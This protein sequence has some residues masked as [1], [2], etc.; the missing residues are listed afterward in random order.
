MWNKKSGCKFIK[1]VGCKMNKEIADILVEQLGIKNF[2]LQRQVEHLK[3][4][5]QQAIALI[6]D[7]RFVEALQLL[8]GK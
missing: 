4:Q 3:E 8:E 6:K 5:K 2:C 1:K 7:G